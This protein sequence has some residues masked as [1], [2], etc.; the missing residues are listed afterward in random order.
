VRRLDYNV[1]NAAETA[2]DNML[3][4]DDMLTNTFLARRHPLPEFRRSHVSSHV[5]SGIGDVA[6]AYTAVGLTFVGWGL[7]IFVVP[8][9]VVGVAV[10]FA[11]GTVLA[12]GKRW[13]S[14]FSPGQFLPEDEKG[15]F[16]RKGG[17]TE[18]HPHPQAGGLPWEVAE[19]GSDEDAEEVSEED[20]VTASRG[21][22]T[23]EPQDLA[24][25]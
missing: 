2:V 5:A 22:E 19:E 16:G 8:A 4:V 20:E 23:A 1:L 10:K 25:T 6:G 11:V 15:V 24:L 17:Q 9:I 12:N 14:E 7:G 18:P 21:E 13:L 3:A